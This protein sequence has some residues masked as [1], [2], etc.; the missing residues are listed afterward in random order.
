MPFDSL[1]GRA[2]RTSA[3]RPASH[4]IY[5]ETNARSQARPCGSYPEKLA[6]ALFRPLRPRPGGKPVVS[7]KVTKEKPAPDKTGDGIPHLG[8]RS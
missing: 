8:K 7:N 1:A 4:L 2:L 3:A 6:R 5:H